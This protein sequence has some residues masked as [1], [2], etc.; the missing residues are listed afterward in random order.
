[1]I[2]IAR[3]ARAGRR[4]EALATRIE[5]GAAELAAFVER[6]SEAEWR[7]PVS[8]TESPGRGRRVGFPSK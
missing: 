4:A 8:A 6:L 5:E 2:G 3:E 7:T 1:M